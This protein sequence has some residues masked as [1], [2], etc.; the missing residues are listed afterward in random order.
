MRECGICYETRL[1]RLLPCGHSVCHD[2]FDQLQGHTCP[3]CRAPFR[4][5]P[6]IFENNRTVDPEYW[7]DYDNREWSV[8][9]R[10]TRSGNEVIRIFRNGEIPQSWRNDPRA[11]VIKRRRFRRR[12]RNNR[13][14][15]Q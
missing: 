5:D 3:Y 9:S 8:Y 12:M 11:T 6:N 10:Y 4:E 1:E 15:V 13:R 14:N 7:L 2:C